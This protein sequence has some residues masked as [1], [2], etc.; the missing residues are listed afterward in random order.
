MNLLTVDWF[1]TLLQANLI[2]VCAATAVLGTLWLTRLR[3]SK[4]HRVAWLLVLLQGIVFFRIP[5]EIPWSTKEA[6]VTSAPSHKPLMAAP[7]ALS[8]RVDVLT[9]SHLDVESKQERTTVALPEAPAIDWKPTL[10]ST[11]LFFW[12]LGILASVLRAVW[13]YRGLLAAL[14]SAEF[15]DHAW[16]SQWAEMLSEHGIEKPI[17][18]KLHDELGPMLCRTATSFEVIVPYTLWQSL[19]H[20]ERATILEHE[21]A[22][23]QRG[24]V[25][26]SLASRLLVLPHWF[27]PVAWFVARRFD[28]A[29]EWACDERVARTSPAQ[30]PN[31]ANVLLNLVQDEPNKFARQL[32]FSAVGGASIANRI[33]RLCVPT[34][35]D[36]AWRRAMLGLTLLS[37]VV[38]S[39]FRFE[40]VSR[41]AFAQEHDAD[42][43]ETGLS[44]RFQQQ[45][46]KFA[47]ELQ[48]D[49]DSELAKFKAALQSE[50]GH[51]VARDRISWIEEELRQR[52]TEQA[53][54]NYLGKYFTPDGKVKDQEFVNRLLK[55]TKEYSADID[56]VARALKKVAAKVDT[57]SEE[58]KLLKRFLEHEASSSI[59]YFRQ[60]RGSLRPDASA[61]AERLGEVFVR[62]GD[63]YEVRAGA[64]EEAERAAKQMVRAQQAYDRI[65]EDLAEFAQEFADRPGLTKELKEALQKPTFVTMIAF[66]IAE[67]EDAPLG[68]RIDE[69]FEQL[70]WIAVD[71][72]DGLVVRDEAKEEA[73]ERLD[74]AKRLEMAAKRLKVPVAEFAERVAERDDL[75]KQFKS[76]LRSDLAAIRLGADYELSSASPEEAVKAMIA[77]GVTTNTA[78]KVMLRDEFKGEFVEQARD[79]MR[80]FRTLMRKTKPIQRFAEKVQDAEAANSL[81]STAGKL[82][83]ATAIREAYAGRSFDGLRR[84]IDDHFEQTGDGYVLREDNEEMVKDFLN[85]M[86]EVETELGSDDF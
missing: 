85:Q 1:G 75:H 18:L 81:K 70:E 54:P 56:R 33:R 36:S 67:D 14:K 23:Y 69:L 31:Y 77:E 63:K 71:A 79:A 10:A 68:A 53:I 6:N 46:T 17:P 80:E 58:N 2:L 12:I 65:R 8:S 26:W 59:M 11:L 38:F 51:V 64:R 61:I 21:L 3:S 72:S 49:N 32:G 16:Q 40:F 50:V 7:A 5:I 30:V 55:R 41:N 66:Q 86:Q 47:S 37:L 42:Q 83:I 4:L 74:E 82:A 52:A 28:E 20:E 25:W 78:G 73:K 9:A 15:A 48:T 35:G 44:P 43:Y 22:H 29:A 45:L 34:N 24:D 13:Q 60:L 76:F 19:S 27:N 57:S 84:W 62:I 39:S